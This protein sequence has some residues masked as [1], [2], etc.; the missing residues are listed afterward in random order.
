VSYGRKIYLINPE[1][2]L[3]LSLYISILVFVTG[4]IY[5]I[6]INSI[7]DVLIAKFTLS[8][9]EIAAHYKFQ[10]TDVLI[11]L[12]LMHL[13]FCCVTFCAC[14]FFSHRIAGPMYKLQKYL[15]DVRE[16]HLEEK[17]F[18][19]KG[20][21]FPELANDINITLEHI[22]DSYKKDL[23]YLSEVNSYI[24]NLS[25]IVPDD[26]K[27]VLNEISSKLTEIQERFTVKK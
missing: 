3:R 18:F 14:I 9:P 20:D 22:E 26:K 8:N 16:G 2:Q 13:G 6:T 7:Y 24:N 17:L 12:M 25:I 19:R 11:Y 21:Y 4:L 27:I 5:P 10:R 23:V 15:K 1:F